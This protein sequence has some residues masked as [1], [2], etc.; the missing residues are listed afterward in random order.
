MSDKWTNMT[1]K[2]KHSNDADC[3]IRI[4]WGQAAPSFTEHK[5]QFLE[6]LSQGMVPNLFVKYG[7]IY[8]CE[9]NKQI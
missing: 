6:H 5:N 9:I 1:I 2:F 4:H 8:L 3:M 7:D